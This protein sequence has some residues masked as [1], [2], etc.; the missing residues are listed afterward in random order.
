MTIGELATL[1]CMREGLDPRAL[2]VVPMSGWERAMRWE[3]TGLPWVLPSPNMPTADTARVYP[4][5]CLLEGAATLSEGRGT[6]RPFELWG[7]PFVDGQALAARVVADGFALRA[8]TFRPTF[9]KFAGEVCGGVQVHVTD[10]PRARSYA[11]Y[12]RLLAAVRALHGEALRWRTETYEFV[13]D[14]PAI[15]LLT[16]GPEA[17]AAIDGSHPEA[18]VA[19]RLEAEDA[20]AVAFARAREAFLLYPHR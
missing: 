15:D 13:R 7:A 19:E 17:R 16:G 6:T 3:S 5:G 14:R 12:L 2:T 8:T 10:A 4:G 20:G 11:L 1:A 9:H 18:A